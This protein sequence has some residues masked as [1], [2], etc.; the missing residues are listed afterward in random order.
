MKH[1]NRSKFRVLNEVELEA[2][3]GGYYNEDPIPDP[4]QD[5]FQNRQSVA[6]MLGIMTTGDD[7]GDGGNVIIVTGTRGGDSGDSNGSGGGASTSWS[8]TMGPDYDLL[9]PLSDINMM[10]GQL[11]LDPT[12]V[13]SGLY[14]WGNGVI[15]GT[16][17]DSQT[18]AMFDVPYSGSGPNAG[19]AY[20]SEGSSS[21]STSQSG[22]GDGSFYGGMTF[23]PIVGGGFGL[24]EGGNTGLFT[25]GWGGTLEFGYSASDE[26]AAA[27]ADNSGLQVHTAPLSFLTPA[28][29]ATMLG[30]IDFDLDP[31]T[32]GFQ[33]NTGIQFSIDEK[34]SDE[35][36]GGDSPESPPSQSGENTEAY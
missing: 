20:S 7:G 34:H 31:L 30:G 25:V 4:I 22:D 19:W 36:E 5:G 1:E 3:G 17:I 24:S 14:D 27:N 28:H 33:L 32:I 6:E 13:F 11:M 12:D 29:W 9:D 15:T 10:L 26:V 8:F 35:S 18:G 21:S 2:V 16:F 23:T